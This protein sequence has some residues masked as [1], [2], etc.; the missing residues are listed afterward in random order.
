MLSKTWCCL[1]LASFAVQSAPITPPFTS[2]QVTVLAFTSSATQTNLQVN[3][4]NAPS[5]YTNNFVYPDF[6]SSLFVSGAAVSRYGALGGS[7]EVMFTDPNAVMQGEIYTQSVMNDVVTISFGNFTG[8]GYIVPQIT[9]HLAAASSG[10]GNTRTTIY[11]STQSAT[12]SP[13]SQQISPNASGVYTTQQ[14]LLFHYGEPFNL[15]F[16]FV[17]L[18]HAGPGSGNA[19]VLALN[20]ITF[21]G[22][23]VFD[24]NLNPVSDPVFVAQSGAQY[25][26]NGIVPLSDV[27]DVATLT[28]VGIGLSFLAL[29]MRIQI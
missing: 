12:L 16:N 14:P 20:T 23:G 27:P 2:T 26:T 22:F 11:A 4:R 18:A 29:K 19:S 28:I 21:T 7:A 17:P 15:F 13:T 25:S 10:T 6:G 24:A 9:V 1:F 5:S 3:G 8:L